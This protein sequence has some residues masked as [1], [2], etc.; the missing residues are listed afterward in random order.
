MD[1]VPRFF[2]AIIGG[3][4]EPMKR[5]IG[6]RLKLRILEEARQPNTTI[7]EVCRGHQISAAQFYAW[8]KAAREAALQALMP[9]SRVR[10]RSQRREERLREKIQRWQAT[11]SEITAEN[12][13]LNCL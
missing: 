3:S 13:E 1:M 11:F 5:Q 6:A 10:D 4:G 2:P 9:K 8:Q 7:A 12:L